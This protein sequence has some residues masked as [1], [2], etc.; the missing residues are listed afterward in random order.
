[1]LNRNPR[2]LPVVRS[3]ELDLSGV[4]AHMREMHPGIKIPRSNKDASAEHYRRHHRYPPAH[5]HTDGPMVLIVA[6]NGLAQER[7]LGWYTGQG[8]V[9]RAEL[10][11]RFR[12]RMNG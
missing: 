12:E 11:R 6:P 2:N 1:M 5:T 8:A 10:D 9:T 4:R 7:W 3:D